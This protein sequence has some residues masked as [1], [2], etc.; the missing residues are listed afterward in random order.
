MKRYVV[1][2]GLAPFLLA[3]LPLAAHAAESQT[4]AAGLL[5]QLLQL[6]IPALTVAALSALTWG[7]ARGVHL[8]AAWLKLHVADMRVQRAI[9][10]VEKLADLAVHNIAATVKPVLMET[11]GK[12]TPEIAKRLRTAALE[13]LTNTMTADNRAVLLDGVVGAE[14]ALNDWLGGQIERALARMKAGTPN[15]VMQA[16]ADLR[17]VKSG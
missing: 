15:G 11:G 9:A 2:F 16:K 14:D 8:G 7:L 3:A 4:L 13:G 5:H 12:V 1:P 10:A 17:P 6:A